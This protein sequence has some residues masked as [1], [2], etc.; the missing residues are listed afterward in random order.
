LDLDC[1]ADRASGED[2]RVGAEVDVG[3][4]DGGEKCGGELSG[5]ETVLFEEDVMVAVGVECGKEAGQ[6]FGSEFVACIEDVVWKGLEGGLGL[7]R[8]ADPGENVEAV[9]EGG[10]E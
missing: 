6:V 1:V 3:D 7:K 4:M 8:D 5:V 10:I 2:R 9:E